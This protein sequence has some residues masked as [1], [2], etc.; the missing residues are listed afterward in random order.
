VQILAPDQRIMPVTVPTILICL[1]LVGL[2]GIV[3]AIRA[4]RAGDDGAAAV[5]I[6]NDVALEVDRKAEIFPRGEMHRAAPGGGG[7]FDGFVDRR[8]IDGDAIAFS[9]VIAN[10]VD[11]GC[12]RDYI[13]QRDVER[14]GDK[15]RRH[16]LPAGGDW[17]RI[18]PPRTF[19]DLIRAT[20]DDNI[21]P[22]SAQR[23]GCA[24]R[25]LA[26]TTGESQHDR[27]QAHARDRAA[28]APIHPML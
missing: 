3:S 18:I 21:R 7:G 12:R 19:R 1:K 28:D 6:Q 17:L 16:I 20:G 24:G 11:R 27:R 9:A 5:E 4:G 8:R 2:G 23:R 26:R 15:P 10:V 13:E 14:G 22:G 25:L